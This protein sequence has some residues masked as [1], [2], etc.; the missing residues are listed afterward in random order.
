MIKREDELT[1]HLHKH[2]PVEVVGWDGSVYP[3]AFNI[4][5]YTPRTGAVHLPPTRSPEYQ[6]R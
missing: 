2:F 1:V 5:D 6:L 3:I 4:H